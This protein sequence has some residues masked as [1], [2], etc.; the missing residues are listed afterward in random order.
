M[1]DRQDLSHLFSSGEKHGGNQQ[2][3]LVEAAGEDRGGSLVDTYKVLSPCS[4]PAVVLP[5]PGS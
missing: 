3:G 4:T 5:A 1:S 2:L